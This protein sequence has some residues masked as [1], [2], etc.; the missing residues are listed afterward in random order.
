MNRSL[1]TAR[2]APIKG[3]Q[4]EIDYLSIQGLIGPVISA[5]CVIGKHRE[6]AK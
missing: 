2:F 5:L 1:N 3:Y 4:K 6:L